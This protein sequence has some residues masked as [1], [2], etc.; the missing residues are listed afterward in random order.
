MLT[1]GGIDGTEIAMVAV[2]GSLAFMLV[3]AI[4]KAV[5]SVARTKAVEES[6]REIAAYV[7]EGS[8]TPED[9][10]KILR[11]SPRRSDDD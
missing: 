10:E 8:M 11:S 5:T 3:A 1:L 6:R 9:A 2:V 4:T 7:A